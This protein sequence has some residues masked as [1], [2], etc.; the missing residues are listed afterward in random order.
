YF[1]G[2]TGYNAK[3]ILGA[4][5]GM[6]N[7]AAAGDMDLGTSADIASN[8]QTAMGIPAE[9]MDHVA[10]VLTAAFTRNNVDIRML[11]DS[12]KYSAG[13]GREYGQSLETVTA[14]TA[15]LGNAGVQGSQAGTSM[16]SVLNRL[17]L[18]KAV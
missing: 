2:R 18:S 16:R 12:L 10:D 7:L 15:L 13:V 9:K 6:L 5:P 14:A 4:M 8:I 3:Q 11:G 17:G 1:L